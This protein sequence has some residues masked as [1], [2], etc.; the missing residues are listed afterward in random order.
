MKPY[1]NLT[2]EAYKL[3][4]HFVEQQEKYNTKHLPTYKAFA[5]LKEKLIKNHER[6]NSNG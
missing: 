5:E 1:T 6:F 4:L 2:P 3:L